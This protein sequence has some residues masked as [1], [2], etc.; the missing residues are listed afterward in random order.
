MSFNRPDFLTE[1][2]KSLKR[3]TVGIDESRIYLFQDGAQSRFAGI[4]CN[5]LLQNECVRRF[6][7]I[8][9]DGQVF[10]SAVNLGTALN[11]DRA[12]RLFF[13]TLEA[14]C[15]LFFEDDLV[16]A[17]Y[18]LHALQ[19]LIDFALYEP[20]VSYV[21]AYGD[22]MVPLEF[23]RS[24]AKKIIPMTHNWG[25]A[26]TRRQWLRQRD[27][28]QG[29]LSIVQESDYAQRDHR[30]IRDYFASFGF[31][32]DSSSQ[33]AAKGVAGLILG[34]KK[35]MCFPCYG[36]YIG[37]NGLH[38]TPEIY[39]QCGY[40]QTILFDQ[41]PP[42]FDLPTRGQL[43][44]WIDS[45]RKHSRQRLA[46]SVDKLQAA[47]PSVTISAPD[48]I[49]GLYKS[50]LGRPADDKGLDTWV[51]A[52]RAGYSLSDIAEAFINSAEFKEKLKATLSRSNDS[53]P[54]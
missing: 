44:N 24:N 50:L 16:L 30:R 28:V 33:D 41:P 18:Y 12:E 14:E 19:Q 27:I 22:H 26:I 6:R 51:N 43:V 37:Q 21:A 36:H 20:L 4:P 46:G 23:Q 5:D 40:A 31:T 13:E 15:A 45:E 3:Q 49:Q 35:V 42:Q 38:F 39:D 34:T 9:P 32:C 11:F 53:N 29:Y 8:F 54:Q 25:F 7:R 47:D 1:V 48:Y 17:P 2:L 52:I 10:Q